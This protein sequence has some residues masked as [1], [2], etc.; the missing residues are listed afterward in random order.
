MNILICATRMSIGGAETHILSLAR[1]FRAMGH[2]VCVA[3]SGGEYVSALKDFGISHV[4]LPL[5]KKDPSSVLKCTRAIYKMVRERRFDVIHAHGRI[6]SFVCCSLRRKKGSVPVVVTVHGIY[7]PTQPRRFFSRFGDHT[8]AVSAD[9]RDH[10]INAYRLK[11]ENITV[12]PNGVDTTA[13]EH[14]DADK[15]RILTA[16]RLDKDTALTAILLCGLM[17]RLRR[18]FPD[19]E[20]TLTIVGGG[21]MLDRV[22]EAAKQA[23][24]AS[25]GA[26]TVIG[27]VTD[28]SK[29]LAR[30]DVF[31]GSSRASLEAMAASIPVLLCSDVGCAG[32]LDE[33]NIVEAERTNFTCRSAAETSSELLR[34]ELERLL[35]ATS[36]ERSALGNFGRAYVLRRASSQ[37]VAVRTIALLRSCIE[38]EKGEIM[39]CGYFGAENLG[40]DATLAAVVSSIKDFAPN[41]RISAP[42]RRGGELIAGVER[43]SRLNMAAISRRMRRTRLFVLC[44]GTLI[45]NSTSNRSLA[46]YRALTLMARRHNAR[47]MIWGGGVGPLFGDDAADIAADIVEE[48]DAAGMRD[49]RSIELCRALGF[50][51]DALYLSADAALMTSP[52]PLPAGGELRVGHCF[53]VSPRSLRGLRRENGTPSEGELLDILVNATTRIADKYKI[54]PLW[55]PMSES[56]VALCRKLCRK[57]GR[58]RVMPRLSAGETV[59]LLS[60]CLFSIGMRLHSAVFSSCAGIPSICLPYDPKVEA[61]AERA[62]HPVVD[63]GAKDL[64]PLSV[65]KIADHLLHRQDAACRAVSARAA[66][67]RLTCEADVSAAKQLWDI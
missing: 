36:T 47:L 34:V 13:P 33:K 10:L 6:P 4:R 55:L 67:L 14:V 60:G 7:D 38:K 29:M 45:Q 20:P 21:E 48:C 3:S 25:E 37:S 49:E 42:A 61:F 23:N 52:L 24:L 31:V 50:E 1:S 30:A 63:L 28:M 2:K 18:D 26:V 41:A 16:S 32:V 27:A 46:Y 11:A 9:V 17:P 40:D 58:G 12:I 64:S 57:S 43:I 53:A 54:T 19:L 5:D 65:I 66:E 22:R 62:G 35:C 59:S 15:L 44:G 56:D 8:I 51:T 39:L